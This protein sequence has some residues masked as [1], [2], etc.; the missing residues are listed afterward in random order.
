MDEITVAQESL[1]L[2]KRDLG[3]EDDIRLEGAADPDE[4]LHAWLEKRIRHLLDH[5]FNGLLNALYRVDIPEDQLK[6]LLALTPT[7]DLSAALTRT[8]L[9]REKQKVETRRKYSTRQ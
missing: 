4:R 9:L 6:Q 1:Q 3:L 8:V 5:D 7:A 2:I